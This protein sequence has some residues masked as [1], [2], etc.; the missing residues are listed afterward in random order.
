MIQK[1]NEDENETTQD[2]RYGSVLIDPGLSS[3][4]YTN[5]MYVD[6][7]ILLKIRGLGGE[8]AFEF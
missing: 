6:S 4:F 5:E 2:E 8:P 7:L 3:F 1:K